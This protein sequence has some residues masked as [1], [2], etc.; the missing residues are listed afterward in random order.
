MWHA[1]PSVLCL[2]LKLLEQAGLADTSLAADMDSAALS[3]IPALR[4]RRF[5]LPQFVAAP[6]KGLV[7]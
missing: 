7:V 2:R 5:E 4:E 3:R 6:D 1:K